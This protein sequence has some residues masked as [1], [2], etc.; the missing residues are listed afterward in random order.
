[1]VEIKYGDLL[2]ANED[3][4]VHQVNV[5]GVMGA[6]VAQQIATK[7]PKTK[8]EYTKFCKKYSFRYENLKGKV[9]L[10]KEKGKYIANIFSQDEKF[11]TDYKAMQIALC[12]VRQFAEQEKLSVAIPYK[13]ACVIANGN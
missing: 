4:L 2:K 7:Y 10:T 6:G 9:D 8:E 1:M 5:V 12:K 11:N 3:I 13:I